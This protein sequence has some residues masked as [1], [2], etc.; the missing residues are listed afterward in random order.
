MLPRTTLLAAVLGSLVL[1]C[2]GRLGDPPESTS[3][4]PSGPGSDTQSFTCDPDATPA[5]VPLRRLSKVQYLNTLRDMVAFALPDEAS[6]IMTAVKPRTD[7]VPDDQKVG[8]T[9]DYGGFQR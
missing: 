2:T 7:I 6:A 9:G 3:N 4:D 5:A 8:P 1:G